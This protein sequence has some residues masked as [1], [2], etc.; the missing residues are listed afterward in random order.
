MKGQKQVKGQRLKVKETVGRSSQL[1]VYFPL[2]P[3]GFHLGFQV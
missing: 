2:F 3:F 1:G